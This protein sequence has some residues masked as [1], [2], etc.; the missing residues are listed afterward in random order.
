MSGSLELYPPLHKSVRMAGGNNSFFI[1]CLPYSSIAPVSDSRIRAKELNWKRELPS[2][3]WVVLG[4][5]TQE[6]YTNTV[7]N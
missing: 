7:G 5:Q 6:R 2:G 1:S 3:K 4:T